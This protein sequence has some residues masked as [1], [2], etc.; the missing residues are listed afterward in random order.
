VKIWLAGLLGGLGLEQR[1]GFY[2]EAG[3]GDH[4]VVTAIKLEK[5]C[6]VVHLFVEN[7]PFRT[8]LNL[9]PL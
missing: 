4:L 2:E 3:C 1:G 8:G 7:C 6:A 5:S 9:L